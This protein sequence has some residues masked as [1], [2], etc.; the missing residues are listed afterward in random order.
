MYHCSAYD[1]RS[2]SYV[3]V[4]E[5]LSYS[6]QCDRH[7]ESFDP[8]DDV[9]YLVKPLNIAGQVENIKYMSEPLNLSHD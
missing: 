2:D 7:G 6:T 8:T 9:R 3:L 5:S 1:L 4:A